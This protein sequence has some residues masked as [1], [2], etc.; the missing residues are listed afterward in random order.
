MPFVDV[1]SDLINSD[2]VS[3]VIVTIV[4]SL[5]YLLDNLYVAYDIGTVQKKL[6]I[7]TS[8]I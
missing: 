3:I 1:K 6:K 4:D 7:P 2:T 5:P 8:P